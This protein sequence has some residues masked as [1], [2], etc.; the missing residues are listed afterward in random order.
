MKKNKLSTLIATLIFVS[1]LSYAM[2]TV[3][4]INSIQEFNILDDMDTNQDDTSDDTN[5]GDFGYIDYELWGINSNAVDFYKIK[6]EA[7]KQKQIAEAKKQKQIA[8]AEKQKQIA[9]AEKQKQIAEAEKQQ[10]II[11]A[12]IE[13]QIVHL[14]KYDKDTD[15]IDFIDGID[16]DINKYLRRFTKNPKVEC[17]RDH[18]G[19]EYH[20]IVL[21]AVASRSGNLGFGAYLNYSRT[22]EI[23]LRSLF[24]KITTIYIKCFPPKSP[25]LSQNTHIRLDKAECF[26]EKTKLIHFIEDVIIKP[27]FAHGVTYYRGYN[28]LLAALNFLCYTKQCAY[29]DMVLD[30][31]ENYLYGNQTSDLSI[32]LSDPIEKGKIIEAL[33][34]FIYQYDDHRKEYLSKLNENKE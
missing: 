21:P 18:L 12:R 1:P 17:F 10:Q 28:R 3:N 30:A 19:R 13:N 23:R 29:Q 33:K 24:D 34:L 22:E 26:V 27:L 31:W 32:F 25:V 8:E 11:K 16:P 9:E 15:V 6:N 5:C 7:E 20:S 2:E 4:E 14:N